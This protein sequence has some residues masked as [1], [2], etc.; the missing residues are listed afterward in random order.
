MIKFIKL[1]LP[2]VAGCFL[3]KMFIAVMDI[4]IKELLLCRKI[5]NNLKIHIRLEPENQ[6]N[7]SFLQHYTKNS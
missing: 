1:K 6:L 5:V 3:R 7:L 2:F 4:E